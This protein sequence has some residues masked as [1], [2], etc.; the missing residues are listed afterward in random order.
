MKAFY[1]TTKIKSGH[2]LVI[3]NQPYVLY[4][5]VALLAKIKEIGTE[6]QIF[7]VGKDYKI[8]Y[9]STFENLEL[10]AAQLLDTV[11]KILYSK[12]KIENFK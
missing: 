2:F 7:A 1:N 3:S 6:I 5:E 11:A 4:Q 12:Q 8:N 10:Q 9:D